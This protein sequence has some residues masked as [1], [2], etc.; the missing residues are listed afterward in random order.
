MKAL[1]ATLASTSAALAIDTSSLRLIEG[2]VIGS[3]TD[4]EPSL[5]QPTTCRASLTWL[6]DEEDRITELEGSYEQL[7]EL[8]TTYQVNIGGDGATDFLCWGIYHS[9]DGISTKDIRYPS[10]ELR[11]AFERVILREN[12]MEDAIA[13]LFEYRSERGL[14]SERGAHPIE[15]YAAQCNRGDKAS[16]EYDLIDSLS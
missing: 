14:E 6:E 7:L 9:Y 16:E 1:F 11:A 3:K 5:R 2:T 15:G 8:Q 13:A 10:A 12:A 4:S